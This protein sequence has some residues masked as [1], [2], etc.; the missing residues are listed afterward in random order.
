MEFVT[1]SLVILAVG[2]LGATL[3]AWRL[4]NDR[5]DV[6]LLGAVT[7]F[8]GAGAAAAAWW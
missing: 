3:H 8:A 1:A 2:L 6:G 7:G 5:R 4:G